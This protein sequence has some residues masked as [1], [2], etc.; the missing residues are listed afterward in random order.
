MNL[1]EIVLGA[2]QDADPMAH[3][4]SRRRTAATLLPLSPALTSASASPRSACRA[5][6]ARS[7]SQAA[8]LMTTSTP[9]PFFVMKIGSP[10]SRQRCAI[11]WLL[12]RR[13][14]IGRIVE[15]GVERL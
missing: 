6:R 10:V 14:E 1:V 12:F 15:A 5:L 7:R 3:R 4:P 11:S 13:S 8:R 9:W 2:K